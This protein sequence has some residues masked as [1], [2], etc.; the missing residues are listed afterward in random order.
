MGVDP[1][2]V[3]AAQNGDVFALDGLIDALYPLVRRICTREASYQHE[4]ATQEAMLAIFRDLHGLRTPEA[5]LSWASAVTARTAARFD[6]NDRRQ[7]GGAQAGEPETVSSWFDH[8]AIEVTDVLT[9]LPD[10]DHAVLVLRDLQ[11]LSEQQTAETLGV[12]VGTVKS[13][14]SRARK[15]FREQWSQ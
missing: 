12:P 13:R 9:R 10:R 5:I 4:D 3:R 14:V 1:A 2:L 7:R 8:D 6:R 11:G 15:R